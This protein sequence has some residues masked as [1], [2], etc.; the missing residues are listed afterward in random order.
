MPG[1]GPFD[2]KNVLALQRMEVR[3]GTQQIK[4]VTAAKPIYAG[5]DPYNVLIDRNSDDN[6]RNRRV[7]RLRPAE[8]C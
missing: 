3:S 5:A 4:L 1:W 8:D 6:V 2:A 7:I